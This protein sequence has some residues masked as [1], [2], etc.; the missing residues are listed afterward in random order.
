MR[1]IKDFFSMIGAIC[2]GRYPFPWKTFLLALLCVVY[3]IS[4][5]DFLPDVMPLLG[6]TDDATFLLLVLAM[7]RQD[8]R[9]YRSGLTPPNK[10]DVIDVGDFKDHKK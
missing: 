2:Q 8:I 1:D 3:I 9:K 7:I 6:I 10:E 5:V 4:P